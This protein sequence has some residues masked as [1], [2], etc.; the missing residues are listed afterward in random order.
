MRRAITIMG[1][2]SMC[3]ETIKKTTNEFV[4]VGLSFSLTTPKSRKTVI[5]GEIHIG[6][7]EKPV[8][9]YEHFI[10]ATSEGKVL[11]I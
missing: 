9:F 3:Q 4:V 5:D 6:T 8:Q 7:F 11:K 10:A 1:V 2:F